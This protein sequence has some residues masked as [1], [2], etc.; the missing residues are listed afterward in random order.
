MPS[1]NPHYPQDERP[2]VEKA[3]QLVDDFTSRVFPTT[4]QSKNIL[5]P[6]ARPFLPTDSKERQEMPIFSGFL[7]YFPR[8]VGAVARHSYDSN[9][10]HNPGERLHWSEEKAPGHRNCVGRHLIDSCDPALDTT[11]ELTA[12]AW[13]AMALLETHLKGGDI[14]KL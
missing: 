6:T 8:A 14:N 10:T 4:D 1:E 12:L 9:E 11:K 13:R 7:E 5:D 3:V 2:M